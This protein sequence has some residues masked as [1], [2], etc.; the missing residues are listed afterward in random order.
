M[1]H[2]VSDSTTWRTSTMPI[3]Q[4]SSEYV[5]PPKTWAKVGTFTAEVP[6]VVT[7]VAW[8]MINVNPENVN[9]LP[10]V[11]TNDDTSTTAIMNPLNSPMI[12][13]T[14]STPICAGIS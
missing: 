14:I 5:P 13:A 6:G 4:N 1:P 9:K 7:G 2:R 11:T 8:E 12:P 3:A 10:N